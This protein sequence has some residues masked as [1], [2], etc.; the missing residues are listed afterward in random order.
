MLPKRPAVIPIPGARHAE[1]VRD[2]AGAA[3][4]VLSGNDVRAIEASFAQQPGRR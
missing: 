3:D 1:S 2:S 4:V